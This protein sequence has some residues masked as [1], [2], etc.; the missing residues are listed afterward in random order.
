M[1]SVHRVPTISPNERDIIRMA[2]PIN[3]GSGELVLEYKIQEKIHKLTKIHFLES[4]AFGLIVS[5]VGAKGS[6]FCKSI[7]NLNMR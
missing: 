3:G 1:N 6:G 5:R 2:M 7:K 4:K